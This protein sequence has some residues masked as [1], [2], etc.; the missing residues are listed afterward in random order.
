[1][2]EVFNLYPSIRPGMRV[3]HEGDLV[4]VTEATYIVKDGEISL[5][6]T[7]ENDKE[8][9][10]KP[11]SNHQIG[12]PIEVAITAVHSE[13]CFS[14]KNMYTRFDNYGG[15]ATV[16]T[17]NLWYGDIAL[18]SIFWLPKPR[19]VNFETGTLSEADCKLVYYYRINTR[20]K[21]MGVVVGTKSGSLI[22]PLSTAIVETSDELVPVIRLEV[23]PD[24]ISSIYSIV[25]VVNN[26]IRVDLYDAKG[27]LA[28]KIIEL[29][30]G[31]LDKPESS[32]F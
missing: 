20:T 24:G 30:E 13:I 1:M 4:Q 5:Q 9:K 3:I 21:T 22:A 27:V 19:K 8:L 17:D 31:V 12:E 25:D 28:Y 6:A 10:I 32:S 23:I 16:H 15:E 11:F 14:T 26:E 18:G 7:L 2:V 29:P